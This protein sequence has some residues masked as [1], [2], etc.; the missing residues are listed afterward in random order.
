VARAGRGL[1]LVRAERRSRQAGQALPPAGR[2]RGG[3]GGPHGGRGDPRAVLD[4]GARTA[5]SFIR[6]PAGV[7]M[8]IG[9]FLVYVFRPPLIDEARSLR[10][11]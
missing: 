6:L 9:A 7:A 2:R 10:P 3:A 5:P 11:C 8:A 4:W 1:A